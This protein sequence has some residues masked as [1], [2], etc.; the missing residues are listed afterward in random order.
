M[1]IG[2]ASAV[3]NQTACFYFPAKSKPPKTV[4]SADAA[5]RHEHSTQLITY[6]RTNNRTRQFCWANGP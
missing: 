5:I 2:P 6:I 3:F 1:K 4:Q